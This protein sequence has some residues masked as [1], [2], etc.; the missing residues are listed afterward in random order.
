MKKLGRRIF[1]VWASMLTNYY[2]FLQN[3]YVNETEMSHKTYTKVALKIVDFNS[4]TR[5]TIH[6][7]LVVADI[8]ES[9]HHSLRCFA[10]VFF[11]GFSHFSNFRFYQNHKTRF[12]W[13]T[14]ILHMLYSIFDRIAHAA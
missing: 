6:I 3:D 8:G 12:V 4:F 10:P 14:A 2:V 11:T 7:L 9:T 5:L 13:V 1:L